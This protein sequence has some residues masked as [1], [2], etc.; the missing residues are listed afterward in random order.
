M[1]RKHLAVDVGGTFVDFVLFDEMTGEV[2]IEKVPSAGR[3]ERRFFEGIDRLGLSLADLE[4]IIH[5]STLVI[6][7]ILQESGARIGLI[8]TRGFRD[9]L[10]LGRGN[11]A[12]IY[13]LFYKPP[14]PLVP[15]YLRYEV[16]ER[17]NRF[18]EV[19]QPLDEEEALRVVSGLKKQN[20]EGIAIC[21]LHAYADPSHEKRM[22]QIVAQ[23]F[24]EAHISISSDIIR[25]WREFERCSTAVL[26]VYAKP[27]MAAYLAALD[28]ALKARDFEKTLNIMQSSGGM[29]SSAAAQN[30]PIR[31]LQSGPAGGVI[32]AAALGAKL[33]RPNLVSAD[34]GGTSFDV[35]LI[36]RGRPFEKSE[37]KVNGRPILQPTVDIVSIG[38]GGGSIAWLDEAGGLRVG[39]KSA[40]ADPGPACLGMGGQEPT[41]TDAQVVLGYL[42][43]EYY[44]GRRMVLDR[45]AAEAAI[46]SRI[47]D[48]LGLSLTAAASGIVRLTNSNMAYAIRNIT[49]E[50]GHDP[51]LFSL[52]AF[53]GG[54]GLFAGSLMGE[55]E[56]AQAIIPVSPATFSAW[57]LLNADFREDLARTSVGPLADLHPDELGEMLAEMESESLDKLKGDG[58]SVETVTVERF[59]DLRYLGQEHAL[60]VPIHAAD[61]KENGH[62]ALRA[63]FDTLHEKAYAHAL[64]QLPV[65]LVNLRVSAIGLR[66]KPEI[67]ELLGEAQPR[68]SSQKASRQLYLGG[69]KDPLECPVYDRERLNP[70]ER[71]VGP[72][73]IEEWTC[74]SL[75][76]A[77]QQAE[78]DLYGNLILT[79][80]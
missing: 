59:A 53:G 62:H 24:P 26:N 80:I 65:E 72:A 4:T 27:K 67:L 47:A 32:G 44:L 42:D 10:E 7:T 31:T 29:T 30:G 52:V 57:G 43:P 46:Q 60:R 78:V 61:I 40:E 1:S 20:V 79:A 22:A 63:R 16:P 28:Q 11:R 68:A 37:A 8:T 41:V 76:L 70:G 58:I 74:T 48:P 73:I 34:V 51:R 45:K 55:L 15:R 19:L 23:V 38:A 35:S 3:L 77:G 6:N 36:V 56:M 66:R 12:E 2:V 25:E 17:I 9:V 5:G 39:P 50:R 49:I 21:F 69:N 75:V 71:L 33:D 54:G 64:P 18:G 13:N 14:P